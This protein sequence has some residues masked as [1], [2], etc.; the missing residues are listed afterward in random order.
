MA[1]IRLFWYLKAS[2][3]PKIIARVAQTIPDRPPMTPRTRSSELIDQVY[4]LMRRPYFQAMMTA[5]V[6]LPAVDT[7]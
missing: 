2:Y 7:G 3:P 6:S 1:P 5:A 4:W